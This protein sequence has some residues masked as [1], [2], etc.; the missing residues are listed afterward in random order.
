MNLTEQARESPPRTTQ[1]IAA[2][3][4]LRFLAV[5][6]VVLYHYVAYGS[7]WGR[8]RSHVFPILYMP[9]SYGWLGVQL[10]FLISGFVICLSCW[11]RS[12]SDFL[13]SRVVRLFPAYWLAVGLTTLMLALLPG[14]EQPRKWQDVLTNL[15]MLQNPLGVPYVDGVYWSLWAEARFYLIFAIVVW[16]GL[17]YRRVLAFCLIW[18]GAGVLSYGLP[19]VHL[20]QMLAMPEYCW[21]FIGGMAFY[22]MWRFGQDLLLWLLVGF[23]LLAGI[24]ASWPT[25]QSVQANSAYDLPDWVVAA[26]IAAFYLL[27]AGVA[28]GWFRRIDWRWLGTAGAV[29]YPLYLLHEYIGWKLIEN[30]RYTIDPW[31]LL[32]ALLLV[33]TA[34]SWLVNRYIERPL[35]RSMK[36]QLRK[37]FERM[38]AIDGLDGRPV[39][40]GRQARPESGLQAAAETTPK[41][42]SESG[43]GLRG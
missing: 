42:M 11:G 7:G 33:M 29:T 31:L 22:L 35:S 26:V 40:I 19:D 25:Y 6:M 15:T 32:G 14:S 2:L 17:T 3:D 36:V 20:L 37:S 38:R 28:L 34:V 41:T 24:R 4:G 16:G 43:V 27:M 1:R 39:S 5:L 23:S 9:A 30:L 13:T 21:F 8:P 12:L 10:F 18:S